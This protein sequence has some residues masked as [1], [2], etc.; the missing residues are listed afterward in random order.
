MQ[1]L[2]FAIAEFIV[3]LLKKPTISKIPAKFLSLKIQN[4]KPENIKQ[5]MY[6]Q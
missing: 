2:S 1:P 5:N 6:M 3:L 4:T